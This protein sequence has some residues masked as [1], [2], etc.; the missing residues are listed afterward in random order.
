MIV[1]LSKEDIKKYNR[2][3]WKIII[4]GFFI[5]VLLFAAAGFGAFYPLPSLRDLENPKSNQASEIISDDGKTVLGTWYV[6]NRSNVTYKELSPNLVHA[7]VAT[8]DTRFY[9]HSGIDFSRTFTIVFYNLIGKKQ[10]GSTITQQLAR[11]QFSNI[12][13]LHGIKR[14]F[15]KLTEW[16]TAVKIERHYTKEEIITMY[17]NTVPFG[18]YNV[19]GVKMAARTYFDTTPDQLTPDQAALLVGMVNGPG[20]YSPINHPDN[21]L[22]RRNFVLGRMAADGFLSDEQAAIFQEK[23]L[24]LNFRR[25]DNNE[26]IAPYFRTSIKND[27]KAILKNGNYT[28]SDGTSY[29][30][31]R[32]GLKIY[33]TIN[34][35]MQR[36]AEEAQTTY[37]RDLQAQFNGQF[38]GY[39]LWKNIKN[40]KLL[41][42]QGMRRSDRYKEDTSKGKS[43]DE[44]KEEFN[45]PTKLNLFTWRGDI[46]TIM[47]PIDSIVYCKLLLRNAV[48]SMDPTNGHIKAWVGGINFAHFKYD[49]VR[50][51]T[52]QVGST[53]KPF[54]YAVAIEHGFSPCTIIPNEPVTFPGDGTTPDWTPA[55]YD[56]RPGPL[57]L[58]QALG[59]S[60]NWI[61]AA[62]MKEVGPVEV[63]QLTKKMGITSEVKPYNPIFLGTFDASVFDMTGAYAAFAN[64]GFWNEPNYLVRI[65]DKNGNVLYENH[66]AKSAQVLNEQTAYVM[67]YMLKGVIEDGTG[68]RLRWKYNLTNPI[69]G[70][71][72]TTQDNS[73][74]WFIGI[75]PQLVTGIWTGCED[76]DIH[77]LSTRLGEGSNSA[78]PIFALYMQ[79]VYANAA[80]GI[81]KN[82]DFAPPKN[83]TNIITDCSVY[84]QQQQQQQGGPSEPDKKLGF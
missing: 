75:T 65:E 82:V 25:I 13:R 37:M 58:R 27:I 4:G 54:T 84:N 32:D 22:N 8:E 70:K 78:L 5:V 23:P 7:L 43:E 26:G 64:Q 29:D 57:T 21:A 44:I 20:I 59:W 16:I 9:E 62:L 3:I 67:T 71:T 19:F 35:D 77:F 79:K 47:K 76:R 52:R 50:Q 74:G 2:N 46:D 68:T 61:T 51:G 6:Q 33:T 14:V 55:S 66:H 53:A 17:F 12:E 28:K 36:Y 11:N 1:K 10:G 41:L 24:G 80:L 63:A 38:K 73:D 83:G 45:T 42:D 34:A 15:Q 72:G 56:T 81:K 18:A 40:Y 30:L 31:D 49:Q 39:S 48:M 60:Q 69:G